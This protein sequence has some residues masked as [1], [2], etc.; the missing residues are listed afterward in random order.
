[1]W[2][3]VEEVTVTLYL[4]PK[5]AGDPMYVEYDCCQGVIPPDP[6][7][8]PVP[9]PLPLGTPWHEKY[10]VFSNRYELVDFIDDGDGL[11]NP[12]DQILLVNIDTGEPSE[13]HIFDWAT[14]IIVTPEPDKIVPE[15]PLGIGLMMIMALVIP[16]A[17]VWRLRRK[18]TKQ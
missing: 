2:Y 15:F 4:E 7:N 11:F 17:Y 6:I 9:W 1:M 8:N 13:W 14:D 18:V 10:P 5:F 3:H 16:T 12:S